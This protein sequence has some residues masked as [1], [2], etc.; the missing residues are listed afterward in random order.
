MRLSSNLEQIL[1]RSGFVNGKVFVGDSVGIF[2]D[3]FVVVVLQF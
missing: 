3:V 2:L 1:V